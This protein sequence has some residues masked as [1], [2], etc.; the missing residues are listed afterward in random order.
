MAELSK[1][2]EIDLEVWKSIVQ[3]MAHFDE[4][5]NEVLR[6]VF[7]LSEQKR[8]IK[9]QGTR[10][11][12]G[13][14][15]FRPMSF[16]EAASRILEQAGKALHY[17]EILDRAKQQGLIRTSGKT[18]HQTMS[19]TLSTNSKGTGSHFVALGKGYYKLSAE[20]REGDEFKD[21]HGFGFTLFSEEYTCSSARDVLIDVFEKLSSR[22]STFSGKFVALRKH[23]RS[24][25]FAAKDRDELYPGR[26]DLGRQFS[27]QLRSGIWVGTNYSRA[28][29]R[30]ILQLAS[31]VAGLKWG[32][33]LV[34]YLGD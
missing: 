11:D 21:I 12:V 14:A 4:H 20:S 15:V 17:R 23:G 22:D 29:I 7:G 24:R 33:D 5:P 6:R 10:K 19:V 32:E 25:R 9:E 27:Q 30:Q 1:Q 2:I 13:V 31:G 16:L 26:P 28:Q 8:G 34:V 3:R 18:P